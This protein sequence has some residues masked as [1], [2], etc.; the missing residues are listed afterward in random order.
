MDLRSIR[1]MDAVAALY[2][3]GNAGVAS[4]ILSGLS[5]TIFDGPEPALA[6]R[7]QTA[8][9][10]DKLPGPQIHDF[11]RRRSVPEP[12][13]GAIRTSGGVCVA[14]LV[15]H[16]NPIFGRGRR[17]HE[18]ALHDADSRHRKKC[19][20]VI[21]LF[22]SSVQGRDVQLRFFWET[23]ATYEQAK[24][25]LEKGRP[26]HLKA[27]AAGTGLSMILAYDRLVRDGAKNVVC[28]ITDR[29]AANTTKPTVCWPRPLVRRGWHLGPDGISA[30]TEDIFAEPH[31]TP[32]CDVVTT[33]GI[34]NT[35]RASLATPP[36]AA[37]A[38][39]NPGRHKPFCIWRKN[40]MRSPARMPV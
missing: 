16:G 36:N 4:A 7:D 3:E 5:T 28:Q 30:C 13:A 37:T 29:D 33:V 2:A 15:Q 6:P 9:G 40:S 25:R 39:P 35:C 22:L 14:G 8:A 38:G 23:K 32:A 17:S 19:H 12:H 31:G 34:L 24:S 26:V 18:R 27:L 10:L 1:P 21:K 11:P 20:H